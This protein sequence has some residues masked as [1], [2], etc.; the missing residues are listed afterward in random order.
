MWSMAIEVVT[1]EDL[2]EFR[3]QLL[4]DI[5]QLI[6]PSQTK[7]IKPWLKNSEVRKLLN[8]SSNTIQRLRIAG[9]LCS[10][11]VGGTHYYRYEDIEKLMN[12][13]AA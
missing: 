13:N 12:N 8:I 2:Q 10:S 11:K 3:M 4:K 7:L 5:R 1:K 9:K 6:T